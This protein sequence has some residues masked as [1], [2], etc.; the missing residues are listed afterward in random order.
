MFE[1]SVGHPW[2]DVQQTVRNTNLMLREK[3][4]ARNMALGNFDIATIAKSSYKEGITYCINQ[5]H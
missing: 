3:V 1:R 2:E 4:K 5:D